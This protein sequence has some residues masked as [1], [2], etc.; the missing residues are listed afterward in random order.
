[1]DNF[2]SVAREKMNRANLLILSGVLGVCLL[3]TV[4]AQN[5]Q[6]VAPK[7]PKTE[8]RKIELP[9]DK[10]PTVELMK[11]EEQL[12]EELKGLVFVDSQ[13][14]VAKDAL[15]KTGIHIP[16]I[17]LEK[18]GPLVEKLRTYLGKPVSFNLLYDIANEVVLFYRE[19]DR[20]VVDV[21][22]PE[23]DVTLGVVQFVVVE[24]R[25]GA[26]SAR[27]NEWFDSEVL[28]EQVR[29]RRGG[30]IKAK[31]ILNDLEWLNS[32]PF[33]DVDVAFTPGKDLGETDVILDVRDRFPV[34]FFA[35]YEDTGNDTTGD[36]RWI[37][38]MNWGDAFFVDHQLSYQY[39]TSSDFDSLQAHSGVYL[40]PLP[41]RHKLN[42]FGSRTESS[43]E[44]A[45]VFNIKGKSWQVGT[46]YIIPLPEFEL[47]DGFFWDH[48]L[49]FGFDFKQTNNNLDFGGVNVFTSTVDINQW[50]AA[51]NASLSDNWGATSLRT[52]LFYSP[53]GWS[54]NNKDSKFAVASAFAD[55]DY[56]YAKI[57]LERVTRL[58]W[59]FTLS[60]RFTFQE[61]TD[62]LLGSE[63][64]GFGGYDSIRGYD[65][66]ER[67]GDSGFI[68]NLEFRTP[69][70]SIAEL[71]GAE[72]D[73]HDQLQFL[74]FWDYGQARLEQVAAG[75][76]DNLELSSVGPGLRY[77]INPYF[78]IRLDYGFQLIDQGNTRRA[79]RF[80]MGVLLSY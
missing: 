28:T 24:G 18:T 64:L 42:V 15:D 21:V 55:A 38:G 9:K 39:T 40:I 35:G 2:T 19:N 80:H 53:G 75:V 61:S 60:N 46:R 37:A 17:A 14:K 52:S 16:G 57:N 31:E 10:E 50:V 68:S 12:V 67:N 76:D 41:W 23:Q 45:G 73:V 13:D 33:R 6:K 25:M 5:Y 56:F 54:D 44:A 71:F 62:C 63:Q 47:A 8:A 30:K 27:G 51:Y 36:E 43:G 65:E 4:Q 78:S 22:V 70:V 11:E 7:Q 66:R 32:N 72:K 3:G 1:M 59:D 29:T 34:R 79:S 74:F 49:E 77:E 48:E 20:P 69:S 58:P 26:V